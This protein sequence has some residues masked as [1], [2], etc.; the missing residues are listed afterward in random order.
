MNRAQA[1]NCTHPQTCSIKPN[2]TFSGLNWFFFLGK[3]IGMLDNGFMNSKYNEYSPTKY[4][5]KYIVKL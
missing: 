4:H 5:K 3:P 2:F 1:P